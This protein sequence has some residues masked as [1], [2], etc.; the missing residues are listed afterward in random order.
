MCRISQ[1]CIEIDHGVEFTGIEQ[2]RA[3]TARRVRKAETM[4]HQ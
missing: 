1:P 3:S 4:R 2:I